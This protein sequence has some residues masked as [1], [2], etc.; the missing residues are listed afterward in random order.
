[1][2]F[3]LTPLS[4]FFGGLGGSRDIASV[5]T[6]EN[7]CNRS[8]VRY[9]L[10]SLISWLSCR[11]VSHCKNVTVLKTVPSCTEPITSSFLLTL[12]AAVTV[13]HPSA[14]STF[15]GLGGFRDFASVDTLGIPC[16][17]RTQG[18]V[19]QYYYKPVIHQL[20]MHVHT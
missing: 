18:I 2:F 4:T 3:H 13:V 10:S 11:H 14:L 9:L 7:S 5:D 19:I 15:M 20:L 1:M 6:F 8:T 17:R 16:N 12:Q